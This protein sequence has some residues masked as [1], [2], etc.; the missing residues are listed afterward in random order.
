MYY[1]EYDQTVKA[2]AMA[3]RLQ[4]TLPITSLEKAQVIVILGGD[5]FMLK[6]LHKY[7]GKPYKIY[8][9]NCG[10]IGF[11][12]NMPE[13]TLLNER[14]K[15]AQDVILY[16]LKANIFTHAG[17]QHELLAVN[18][19]YVFRATHQA[20]KIRIFVDGVER[21]SELVSDG[22]ILSTPAGS[23]AYNLS[24]HGPIIPI[25][26]NLLALTPISPFRPRRWRGA[27][28]PAKSQVCW[29]IEEPNKRPVTAVADF[30]EVT[31]VTK[32]EITEDRSR[33]IHLLFDPKH[34]LE[35]RIIN[36]QFIG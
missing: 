33:A 28:L 32:I 20:A 27:L 4:A 7:L 29:V 9:V 1:I 24:A 31:G 16:P 34:H 8:G 15:S 17:K 11:L 6:K 18:E 2:K 35:E 3:E 12:M 36:E 25:G 21:L 13:E 23:T 22:V 19:V 26:A 14:I 10:R 30:Q 5:G